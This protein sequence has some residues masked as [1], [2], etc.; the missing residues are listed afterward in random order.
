MRFIAANKFFYPRG[1]S[2]NSF[3]ARN[4]TLRRHG[5]EVVE[6]SVRSPRNR[7]SAFEDFFVSEVDYDRKDLKS[8]LVGAGNLLY[9][10]EARSKLDQLIKKTRPDVASLHNIYHQIS[11]SIIHTLKK[12]RIPII[13]TL[14]DYKVVCAIYTLFAKDKIC[15]SCKDGKYIN[16]FLKKC[17][18][19]R[20]YLSALNTLEMYLH[21]N[22]LKLYD[23]VDVFVSPSSFL[24]D[25]V[26]EMGFKGKVVHLFNCID[27]DKY[28]PKYQS[29]ENSIVYFG[30]ISAEKGLITLIQAMRGFPN[31]NLKI[32]GEG[33]MRGEL[34][35]LSQHLNLKNIKFHG[36]KTGNE[37]YSEILS[38]MFLILPSEWY[39]NNPRA[40]IE[41]FALGK[42]VIGARI[43]GIPELVKDDVTGFTFEPGNVE[44]LKNKI[45]MLLNS[46]VKIS[47]MG[48]NARLFVERELNMDK[49]YEGFMDIVNSILK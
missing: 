49:H 24:V 26:K 28:L 16:C 15:E 25:K 4:E 34:E 12:Y 2:E 27:I 45:N 43:G 5:H 31:V 39:E 46:K 30:R 42:P 32:I 22:V 20:R 41:G 19:G 3:F 8:R 18:K 29:D 47:A 10:F 9:S 6:F 23:L 40:V 17:V 44:D 13:M 7:R 1:G 33:P 36:Y 14:H 11:P 37:L 35:A 38:S 48:K 21:H